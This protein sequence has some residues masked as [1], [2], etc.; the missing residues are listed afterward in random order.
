[1][2]WHLARG[3]LARVSQHHT[4]LL[5]PPTSSLSLILSIIHYS[6]N[7]SHA[8]SCTTL[9]QSIF[10]SIRNVFI[11]FLHYVAS[12]VQYL[13]VSSLSLSLPPSL[14]LSPLSLSCFLPLKGVLIPILC[15]H[16]MPT[17]SILPTQACTSAHI[18][19]TTYTHK[20][21]YYK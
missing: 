8:S 5:P 7:Q 17:S 19:S 16:I 3:R 18:F 15:T 10:S 4:S 13:S 21:Y 11:N 9:Q 20:L 6:A 1:M 2:C 12:I 14:L